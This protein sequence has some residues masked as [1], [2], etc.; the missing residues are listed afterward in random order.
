MP[1]EDCKSDILSETR[2]VLPGIQALFGFQFIAVFNDRFAKLSEFEKYL[3]LAAL[4]AVALATGLI[5]SPAAIDRL[6]DWEIND[7]K[8]ERLASMLISAAMFLLMLAITS[9]VFIIVNMVTQAGVAIGVAAVVGTCLMMSWFVL[10]LIL[11]GG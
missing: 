1:S 3:H 2:M 9:E 6:V 11:R 5:M 7:H 8:L 4:I 10:P